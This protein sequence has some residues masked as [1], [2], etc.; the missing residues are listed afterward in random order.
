[1][2]VGDTS[3]TA[4]PTQPPEASLQHISM[5]TFSVPLYVT[6]NH[7][8]STSSQSHQ[9]RKLFFAPFVM[10]VSSCWEL[11]TPLANLSRCG[12][13]RSISTPISCIPDSHQDLRFMLW[14]CAE[15]MNPHSNHRCF[16]SMSAAPQW[17]RRGGQRLC[18]RKERQA[19]VRV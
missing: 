14:R 5:L 19:S 8:I 6:C 11:S 13:C 18:D 15:L 7:H 1:M 12:A 9:T 17:R 2:R 4:V 16:I 3:E 10:T